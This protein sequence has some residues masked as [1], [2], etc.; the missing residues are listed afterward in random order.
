MAKKLFAVFCAAILALS[1]AACSKDT[2]A[3]V[4]TKDDTI[5]TVSSNGGFLVETPRATPPTAI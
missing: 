4:T 3:T 2:K 1:L 5:E